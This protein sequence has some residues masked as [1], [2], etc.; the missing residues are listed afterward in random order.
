MPSGTKKPSRSLHHPSDDWFQSEWEASPSLRLRRSY[1]GLGGKG[2]LTVQDLWAHV[3]LRI[4]AHSPD[5]RHGPSV[6]LGVALLVQDD[7]W[8]KRPAYYLAHG[9]IGVLSTTGSQTPR[10]WFRDLRALPPPT[11]D[12]T[13]RPRPKT[14]RLP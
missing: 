12:S 2:W 9:Q 10:A 5:Y 7:S 14:Q 6:S 3:R 1:C 8:E 11:R 4:V 13:P